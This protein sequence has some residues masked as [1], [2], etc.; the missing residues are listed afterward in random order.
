MKLCIERGFPVCACAHARMNSMHAY[1]FS[2]AHF[3]KRI[4]NKIMNVTFE[5]FLPGMS[6][7]MPV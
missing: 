5:E 2:D 7:H 4:I 1:D 6:A 3:E